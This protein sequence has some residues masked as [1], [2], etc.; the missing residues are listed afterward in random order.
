VFSPLAAL[1]LQ[2]EELGDIAVRECVDGEKLV[3]WGQSHPD[4]RALRRVAGAIGRGA[5]DGERRAVERLD[6]DAA[7]RDPAVRTV[8]RQTVAVADRSVVNDQSADIAT[9]PGAKV[10]W[11]AALVVDNRWHRYA[12]P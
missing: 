1:G 7:R 11:V 2:R 12:L 6:R 5:V 3:R 4:R 9:R 8:D 10:I